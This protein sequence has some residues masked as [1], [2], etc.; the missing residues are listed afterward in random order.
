MKFAVRF[1]SLSPSSCLP[2]C[3]ELSVQSNEAVRYLG[4]CVRARGN[5]DPAIH[6]YLLSLYAKESA[7]LC[8]MGWV[9]VRAQ[10]LMRG[11]G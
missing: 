5:K 2:V 11:R 1:A 7:C 4:W 9:L 8:A 3:S 10:A 6:N